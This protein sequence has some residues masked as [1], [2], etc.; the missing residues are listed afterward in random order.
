MQ[1]FIERAIVVYPEFTLDKADK[2]LLIQKVDGLSLAIELAAARLW[3]LSLEQIAAQLDDCFSWLTVG[4]RLAL[5]KHV[6]HD[7]PDL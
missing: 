3:V 1:R 2:A 4:N 5:P 6:Y 7:G